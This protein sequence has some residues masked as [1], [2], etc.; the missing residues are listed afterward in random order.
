MTRLGREMQKQQEQLDV[1]YEHI[2]GAA[3]LE[4]VRFCHKQ[5]VAEGTHPVY[6]VNSEWFAKSQGLSTANFMTL[7]IF[8]NAYSAATMEI[9]VDSGTGVGDGCSDAFFRIVEARPSRLHV[10][11]AHGSTGRNMSKDTLA[12]VQHRPLTRF[13]AVASEVEI[14]STPS[15]DGVCGS[16]QLL[17]GHLLPRNTLTAWRSAKDFGCTL[18]SRRRCK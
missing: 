18:C 10:V 4:E 14:Q 6:S 12:V 13:T 16:V 3:F 8:T 5:F 17:R 15:S 9:D 1:S 7:P 11:S 2:K